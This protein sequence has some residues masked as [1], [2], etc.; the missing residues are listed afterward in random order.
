MVGFGQVRDI[1]HP[2]TDGE[3]VRI[4]NAQNAFHL[5]ILISPMSSPGKVYSPSPR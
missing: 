5:L 2:F 1:I 4:I 3:A